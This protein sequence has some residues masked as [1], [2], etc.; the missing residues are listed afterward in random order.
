MTVRY[1]R[2]YK[3]GNLDRRRSS[4][5]PL[6]SA[7]ARTMK[8]LTNQT[9]FTELS[10]TPCYPHGGYGCDRWP[11]PMLSAGLYIVLFL[12]ACGPRLADHLPIR[13]IY[14]LHAAATHDPAH[15]DCVV[16]PRIRSGPRTYYLRLEYPIVT[17]NE[18]QLSFCPSEGQHTLAL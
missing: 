14:G 15:Y 1:G 16:V 18:G 4:A 7:T 11:A 13:L 3:A 6:A 8:H 9:R 10:S 5:V 2:S 17:T 12:C